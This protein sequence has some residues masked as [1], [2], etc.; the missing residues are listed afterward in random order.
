MTK[1]VEALGKLLGKVERPF[2]AVLGGAKVSDK[3]NVI[4]NLLKIADVILI[5]G[6]MAYTFLKAQGHAVGGS[7]VEED[8]LDLAA[9]VL[10]KAKVRG[11]AIE[12][13]SDHVCA[14]EFV[15]TA[16]PVAVDSVDIPA[17]LMGLDIGRNTRDRYA[18]II[19]KAAT[20]FW[21][22]PMGVFEW[23]AFSGGT[24]AIAAAVADS[25]AVSVVGGGD[26]VAA[27]SKSGRTKDITH[28]ST[29]GGASL[30]MLEGRDLPGV[31]ALEAKGS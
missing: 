8:K 27:L 14:S 1:E 26:S 10:A 30:E 6:A 24:L 5:G 16:K 13:P 21:N 20:I 25:R 28:V 11:V 17:G 3:I 2:L 12:L 22:G 29:G 18:G 23:D 4:D 7:R 15:E 9:S 19:A 31:V